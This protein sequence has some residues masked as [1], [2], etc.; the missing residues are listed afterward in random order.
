MTIQ[1]A[2]KVAR[3]VASADGGCSTCCAYLVDSLNDLFPEFTWTMVE[4][5][6]F[7]ITVD[8]CLK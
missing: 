7:D 6:E 4:S 3:I 2:I 8:I 5:A 1:E